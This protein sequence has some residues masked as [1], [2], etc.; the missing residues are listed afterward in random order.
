[1]DSQQ[2]AARARARRARAKQVQRRR[3]LLVGGLLVL[4]LIIVIIA[5]K[6]C[7]DG[8]SVVTSLTGT[9]D[10]GGGSATYAAELTGADSVPAVDTQATAT[11]TLVYDAD[12]GELSYQ[13]EVTHRISNPNVATIYQGL[14]GE[15]GTA[16]YTLFADQIE[17]EEYEGMLAEGTISEDDLVGP[18][19]GGSIADLLALIEDGKAYVSIGNERHPV[20]A[21]RGQIERVTGSDTNG[22]D[23]SDTTETTESD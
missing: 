13:L 2:A 16:V 12:K 9:T 8:G 11:L 15:Y 6:S 4:I 17:D 20:D 21:I 1:M 10:K 19:K 14:E 22:G 3:L 18:L 23:T 7:G 5:V